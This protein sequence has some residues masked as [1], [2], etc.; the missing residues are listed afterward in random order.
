MLL[1]NNSK[2]LITGGTGSFGKK[3][4]SSI[5]KKFPN[6][7]RIVIFSRDE[8]KQWELQQKYPLNKYPQLRFFIGDI[9]DGDR[10]KTVD[11]LSLGGRN[12]KGF[13]FRGIGPK[14]NLSNYL[15]G[16]KRYILSIGHTS[17]FEI[18]KG[19]EQGGKGT[20]FQRKC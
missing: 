6:L 4:L 17:T 14:D 5:L 9:R 10:L 18:A 13:D 15:G 7:S 12:F 11:S 16:K 1:R 19:N 2:I 20:N 8:L 3:F